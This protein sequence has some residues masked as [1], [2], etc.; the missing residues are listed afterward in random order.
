MFASSSIG[1]EGCSSGAAASSAVGIDCVSPVDGDLS[2]S[3]GAASS[4]CVVMGA[5]GV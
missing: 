1:G 3:V 5:S 2:A 4:S